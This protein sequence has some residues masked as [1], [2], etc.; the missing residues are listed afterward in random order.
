MVIGQPNELPASVLILDRQIIHD[1]SAMT[2]KE[3]AS[4][5]CVQLSWTSGPEIVDEMGPIV[6]HG[7][8]L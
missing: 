3:L 2:L 4:H 7:N 8:E 1:L 6:S 5:S